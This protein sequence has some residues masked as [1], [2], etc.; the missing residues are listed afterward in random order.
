MKRAA[1]L[2]C[3][4]VLLAPIC[5]HSN[6][7]NEAT[8]RRLV[9]VVYNGNNAELIDEMMAA[10]VVRIAPTPDASFAGREAFKE[11]LG[12]LHSAYPD[13][14]LSIR[15]LDSTGETVVMGWRFEA[16]NTGPGIWPPTG[17]QID[18]SG[19]SYVTFADGKI[20]VDRVS[21]DGLG[22]AVQLGI[23]PMPT[24][25]GA[26]EHTRVA[27]TNPDT[28][29]VKEELQN[30]LIVIGKAHY[31]IMFVNSDSPRKLY[32]DMSNSTDEEKLEAYKTFIANSGTY[33]IDG[34]SITFTP[35]VAKNPNYMSGES[36]TATF[37]LTEGKLRLIYTGTVGDDATKTW[38]TKVD[39][40]RIE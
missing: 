5:A 40:K 33:E 8:I 10:D 7:A 21:W 16:T 17:K 26:W 24:I 11:Y 25:V 35:V 28:S 30:S 36:T 18:L 19:T 22:A 34:E 12:I 1:I 20:V 6:N 14:K 38:T 23:P 32:K 4:L 9:D 2:V 37:S 31:S 27:H 3:A 15:S 29:W 13:F 39:C